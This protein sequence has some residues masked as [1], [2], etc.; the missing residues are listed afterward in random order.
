MGALPR[1]G[2]CVAAAA[3]L[4]W[5]VAAGRPGT[6]LVLAAAV[7]P[8]GLLVR[9]PGAR[10]SAVALAPALGAVGLAGAFPALAGQARGWGARAALGMLGYWWLVLAEALVGRTLWLGPSVDVWPSARWEGSPAA[11]ASHAVW[12]LLTAGVLLGGLLW[13]LG[14]VLLPWIVRGRA[15]AFDVVGAT[16]W[17]AALA[18]TAPLVDRG[19][20]PH[21]ATAAS[22][23]GTVAGAAAG[24][25]VAVLARALRGP[26]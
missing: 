15:L 8:A 9:G 24:A 13:A 5:L 2:W 6:A 12:P 26:A 19:L 23:R 10:W 1:V 25:V 16:M 11:A 17:A 21:S 4:G 20:G 18:S 14:A 22:P 3:I 7:A